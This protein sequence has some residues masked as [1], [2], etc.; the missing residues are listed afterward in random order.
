MALQGKAKADYQR[1]YMR[2]RRA[3]NLTYM[4][5][6]RLS[7]I[8]LNATANR[9]TCKTLDSIAKQRFRILTR[10]NFRCQ[11]CGKTAKD[12][13]KLE[14]DHITPLCKGGISADNNLI[15]AC[16]SCN[17]SKGGR[18]LNFDAEQSILDRTTEPLSELVYDDTDI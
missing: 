9:K 16:V 10:D 17:R 3:N 4:Q 8:G 7:A 15:T 12:D 2:R 18:E 1:E 14:I 11:Y 13:I 5:E 6:Y